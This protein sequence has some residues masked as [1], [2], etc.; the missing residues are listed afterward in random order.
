M[1][2]QPISFLEESGGGD[3]CTNPVIPRDCQK[4][5]KPWRVAV[6][7]SRKLF[8]SAK[9]ARC[10]STSAVTAVPLCSLRTC[11][12]V[13]LFQIRSQNGQVQGSHKVTTPN[14]VKARVRDH[15]PWWLGT[16]LNTTTSIHHSPRVVTHLSDADSRMPPSRDSVLCSFIL[17]KK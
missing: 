1:T 5:L 8:T 15:G 11:N 12:W 17:P 10:P 6:S 4:L 7:I 13:V 2:L 3:H 16:F 9:A 14:R